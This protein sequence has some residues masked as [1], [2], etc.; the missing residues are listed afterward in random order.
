MRTKANI[1]EHPIHP[2]LVAFPIAFY[3]MSLVAF[4]VYNWVNG[5][6][7]WLR[8]G[9]FC[10]FTGVATAFLAAIPGF[11]DWAL[12]IPNGTAAK[13]RGLLHMSLNLSSMLVFI[14]SAYLLRNAWFDIPSRVVAPLWLSVIGVALTMAAGY[15]G[16]EMISKHKMGVQ[17][18]P[19]QERLEPEEAA[20]TLERGP[21]RPRR[22]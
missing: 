19:E 5:D 2:M 3:T 10:T 16:W 21:L 4:I 11:I 6:L 22:I 7:F 8:L 14:I 17:L 18:T 13:A 12:A 15:Q 1:N 20:P 9:I